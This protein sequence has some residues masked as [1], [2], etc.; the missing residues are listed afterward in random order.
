VVKRVAL[1][2]A[3]VVAAAALAAAC[4]SGEDPSPTPSTS[5]T[6]TATSAPTPTE[7]P[8]RTPDPVLLAELDENRQKWQ[9]AGI[10]D[11][12]FTIALMCFCAFGGPVNMEVH[13]DAVS[14]TYE[15]G[16]PLDRSSAGYGPYSGYSTIDLTFGELVRELNKADDMEVAYDPTFGYPT[17][18]RIDRIKTA[19]DDELSVEISAFVQLGG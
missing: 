18:I 9:A 2:S 1:L 6:L 19:A 5:P 3:A 8:T 17:T 10:T 14:M 15:D 7:E 4:S 16:T 11:Y 13:G 12:Q